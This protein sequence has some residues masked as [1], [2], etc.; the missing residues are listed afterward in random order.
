MV[1]S[2]KE[3][4]KKAD[5]KASPKLKPKASPKVAPKASPKLAPKTSPK[6]APKTKKRKQETAEADNEIETKKERNENKKIK[7]SEGSLGVC[8]VSDIKEI[9]DASQKALAGK[10]ITT[11]F[12]IQQKAFQPCFS[13]KDVVGRA[14]TGCGKTLAFVLP[15]VE[16]IRANKFIK[17]FRKKAP[18]CVTIAPTRELARQIFNDFELLGAAGGLVVKCFYGG[19]PFGSQCEDLRNGVHVLVCTPGRLLD[20]VRRQSADLSACKTLVLDEADEMLSMG[21]Q[22]DIEAVMDELPKEGCQKLLFSA[23]L[24]KWVNAIVE[25]HLKSPV[26]IDVAQDP[27]GNK[28]SNLITHQ[29]VACPISMRG[30]CIGDLCKIHAGAFGKTIVFVNTKKDCDE[31]AGNEKL[32]AIG[33]GVLHGDI[34]QQTRDR[35]MEH[36]RSGK[37]RCLVATDVAARGIDVPAVDLVVQTRPPQDLEAYVHRSGRTGRAGRK[38]TSI[39]FYSRS[40]EYL[41]RL[42]EHKKGI[43]MRRV[44]PPQPKDVVGAAADDAVRQLDTVHEASVEAFTAKAK[45]VIEERGAEAALAAAMAALTGHF[46]ELKGRSM[47]SAWEGCTALILESERAIETSSKGWYLLRQML[48]WEIVEECRGCKRC[49]DEH[50]CIFDAPDHLVKKI[51]EVELWRGNKISVAE[52]LPEL[53][54]E[55]TDIHEASQRLKETKQR[56]YERR[57]GGGKGEKGKGEREGKGRKGGKGK[58]EGRG[59]GSSRGRGRG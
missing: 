10:S 6:E 7:K 46:R 30:D 22:E 8:A 53:E 35:T 54:E 12:E 37:I 50:R 51:L 26:W 42:I 34:P 49:K 36:F 24:P 23:T 58:G 31:L 20:H 2:A 5:A 17:Q 47:L 14:K 43:K 32:K 16:R 13:G 11:L 3:T 29:C 55:E 33:A 48:P 45:E 41:L 18:L 39:C 52:E 19:T 9:S 1:K 21:F 4:K 38:G 44:G 28:T 56:M 57:K 15:V 59:K 25:K 40:D 27:D